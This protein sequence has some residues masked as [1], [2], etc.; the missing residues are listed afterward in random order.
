VVR[1]DFGPQTY[2]RIFLRA[3]F[4]DGTQGVPLKFYPWNL[5]ARL[6]GDPIAYEQGGKK[7]EI[8]FG[9]WLDFT[10]LAAAYGWERLPALSTWRLA[11]SAARFDQFANTRGLDWFS[12]MQQI[13]PREALNT[14]TPIP[15][16]TNPPPPTLT[17]TPTVTPSRTPWLS[18]TPTP[19]NTRWPTRTPTPT[20]TSESKNNPAESTQYPPTATPTI[21]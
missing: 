20:Q 4:Q 16:P 3:R 17:P 5:F 11:F 10:Q 19:T 1:E 15:S 9:Y 21:N 6:S 12:A 13:Y 8:P 18:R 7:E 14:T 2:W